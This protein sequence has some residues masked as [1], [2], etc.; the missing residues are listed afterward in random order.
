[1]REFWLGRDQRRPVPIRAVVTIAS[2]QRRALGTQLLWSVEVVL[3]LFAQLYR[4]RDAAVA[5]RGDCEADWNWMQRLLDACAR[6]VTE[7]QARHVLLD[8]V[9]ARAV[10]LVKADLVYVLLF[11]RESQVFVPRGIAGSNDFWKDCAAHYG[12]SVH[13]RESGTMEMMKDAMRRYLAPRRAGR[14]QRAFVDVQED[15]C[16]PV[17]HADDPSSLCAQ[18]KYSTVLGLLFRSYTGAQLDGVIWLWWKDDPVIP[19]LVDP[20]TAEDVR[21]FVRSGS[22]REHVKDGGLQDRVRVQMTASVKARLE[23]IIEAAAAIY[24]VLGLFRSSEDNEGEPFHLKA[25]SRSG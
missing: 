16:W 24:A 8:M 22:P 10:E 13:W 21:K 7:K 23:P 9:C 20:R 11:E 2:P 6:E 18:L 14:T 1:M 4:M 15:P 12:A 19:E 25:Q 5:S 17:D 3:Q